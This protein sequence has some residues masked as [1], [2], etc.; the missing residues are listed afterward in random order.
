MILLRSVAVFP[1]TLK[2]RGPAGLNQAIKLAARKQHRTAGE[3]VRQCLLRSLE[4]QGVRL[5]ENGRVEE[6]DDAGPP[7]R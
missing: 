5:H 7:W 4:E 2:H 6:I 3:F 1:E